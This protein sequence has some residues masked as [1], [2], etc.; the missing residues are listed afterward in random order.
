MVAGVSTYAGS[1]V[2]D[3]VLRKTYTQL[4]KHACNDRANVGALEIKCE[5]KDRSDAVQSAG[6]NEHEEDVPFAASHCASA[7]RDGGPY[8]PCYPVTAI[9]SRIVHNTSRQL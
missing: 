8:L 7:P 1:D 3:T 6:L 5:N 2:V 4:S 9:R